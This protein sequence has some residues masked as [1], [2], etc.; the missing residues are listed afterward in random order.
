MSLQRQYHQSNAD[1]RPVPRNRRKRDD[2]NRHRQGLPVRNPV[3]QHEDNQAERDHP[4]QQPG[5]IRPGCSGTQLR[6]REKG[7]HPRRSDQGQTEVVE[8]KELRRV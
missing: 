6:H 2:Q 8:M 5:T 7:I 1:A 4:V 3:L